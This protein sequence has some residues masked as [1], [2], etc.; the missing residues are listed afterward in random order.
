MGRNEDIARHQA[1][2]TDAASCWTE[3]RARGS[4]ANE[5]DQGDKGESRR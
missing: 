3:G 2:D 5:G 1:R 4:S